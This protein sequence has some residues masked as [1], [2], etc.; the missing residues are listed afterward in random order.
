MPI[1]Y[2]LTAQQ[3]Q[4]MVMTPDLIQAIRIL[5]YDQEELAAFVD[6]EVLDNPLLEAKE[7]EPYTVSLENLRRAVQ[8]A[9]EDA[10]S[11]REWE[12]SYRGDEAD[13]APVLEQTV[14]FRT[15]LVEHLLVQLEFSYLSGKE[16]KLGRYLIENI[17]DN[18]YLSITTQEAATA[19]GLDVCDA[20]KAL[21]V[22]QTFE[23]TG[24]GA[25]DL[26][27]CLR[28]Q[29]A[30]DGKS[31]PL[32]FL[33]VDH[34][35]DDIAAHRLPQIA[36]ALHIER[37]T[38]QNLLAE[39][40]KLEPKPGCLYD[41]DRTIQ[42]IAPDVAVEEQDGG[43]A[44]RLLRAGIPR[45]RVSPGYER[46]LRQ[47]EGDA[48]TAAYLNGR[49]ARAQ[50]LIRSLHQ[51]Q[52][53]IFAVA[54]AIA[55]RQQAYFEK[56]ERFLKPLHLKEIAEALDIS[57]ST[58]SRTVNGKFM[59]SSR[60]AVE[61]KYFFTGGFVTEDGR[62]ISGRGVRSMLSDIIAAEDPGKP[63]SDHALTEMLA[64][65]GVALSRRTVAKYR[66]EMGILSSSK[67]KRF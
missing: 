9:E 20:E 27:E 25:R 57:I 49:F 39:L 14:A 51:R 38:L 15:G 16:A 29:L 50:W 2:D 60:G 30:A 67:R 12:P 45:L 17:D 59:Q 64:R 24:V 35:L 42:Y 48:E 34:F 62:E 1:G 44:V 47:A 55:D 53:T 8:S 43:Y 33:L 63:Y 37:E 6:R 13:I 54:K 32:L 65:K 41:P 58:V 10:H 5:Q 66:E 40:R 26:R 31:D 7:E 61:F 23:P 36:K 52:E 28:I 19:L 22:I 11:F 46:L 21:S 3:S 56:G 18:G 4:K